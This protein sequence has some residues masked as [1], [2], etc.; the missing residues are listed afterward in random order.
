MTVLG[1]GVMG[2]IVFRVVGGSSLESGES[3]ESGRW[4]CFVGVCHMNILFVCKFG[5]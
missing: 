4:G 3:G 5:Q 2:G 1:G